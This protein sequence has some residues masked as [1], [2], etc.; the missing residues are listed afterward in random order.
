MFYLCDVFQLI[1]DS[2]NNSPLPGK[3]SVRHTHDC[4][5]HVALEL[6]YQLYTI[7]E[8]ALEQ[9]LADISFVSDKFP[10]QEFHKSLVLKR[11]SVV[12]VTWSNHE[13]EQFSHLVT[14]K[15]QFEAEKPAHRA[16]AALRNAPEGSMNMNTLVS[17]YPERSTVNETDASAFAQQYF[18]NKQG[19]RNGH[20][21][22]QFNKAV[23][24]HQLGKQV[25][26]MFRDMLQIEMLQASIT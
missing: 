5:L 1:I 11:L 19:K 10:V 17:A 9:F 12:D 20:F 21:L 23:I 2:L 15:M 14:D 24:G 4:A 7:D 22:L 18:L 6:C 25:A 26:K 16:F 8:E 13:I 3:Q